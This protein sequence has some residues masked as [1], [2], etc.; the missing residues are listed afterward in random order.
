VILQIL[1]VSNV[2]LKDTTLPPGAYAS[3][4]HDRP[5]SGVLYDRRNHVAARLILESSTIKTQAFWLVS[6]L[7]G[8][9]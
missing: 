5:A 7:T 4:A 3:H 6:A 9:R 1:S 8:F 2:Q